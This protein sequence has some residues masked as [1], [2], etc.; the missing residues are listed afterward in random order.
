MFKRNW[1]LMDA[2][3]DGTDGGAGGGG[4][5]AGAAAGS[6]PGGDPGNGGAAGT[7]AAA[8]PG[9]A[10]DVGGTALGQGQQSQ[11]APATIPEKYQVKKEDG[12]IDIA[13][14]S[15]KLAEAYGNLEKRIGTGDI[16]PK[17]ADEYDITVPD[18]L[19]ETWKPKEDP[20]LKDFLGKAH[21]A[22]MTQ[23]QVDLVMSQYMELAPEL[24]MGAR[25][26]DAESCTA[27]LKTQWK[28]D[29]QYNAEVGK[30]YRAASAYGGKDAEAIVRDYGNDPRIVRLLANVGKELGEDK[31]SNFDGD[32]GKQGDVDA[33]MTSEAYNNPK[34]ADHARVSQQVRTH[35]EKLAAAAD[36]AGNSPLM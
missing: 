10:G 26:L 12:T 28:T 7:G 35:F 21:A 18:A 6:P 33:I 32:L 16:P 31:S 15:T 2:A 3:G 20:L 19:K 24:V 8:A 13:A 25:A 14:S 22:G 23:K 17:T 30:A 29:E 5:A 1:Y 34:H 4:A 36:K 9:K 11:P 27:E